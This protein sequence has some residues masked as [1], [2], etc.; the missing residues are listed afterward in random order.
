MWQ[1]FLLLLAAWM[2][3]SYNVV[4][5]KTGHDS[6][7]CNSTLPCLTLAGGT[8]KFNAVGLDGEVIQVNSGIYE[9]GSFL[10]FCAGIGGILLNGG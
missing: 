8:A 5:D 3:S 4:V 10:P 2:V 7:P 6:N 9:E 1:L